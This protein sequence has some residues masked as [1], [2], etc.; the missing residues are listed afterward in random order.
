M[1]QL[2]HNQIQQQNHIKHHKTEKVHI[3]QHIPRHIRLLQ[4]L[5][6]SLKNSGLKKGKSRSTKIREF[7][8]FTEN[9]HADDRVH[10]EDGEVE[11]AEGEEFAGEEG[12]DGVHGAGGLQPF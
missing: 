7:V 5:A 8:V 11:K 2:G 6:I 10:E 9:Y 12:D 1:H 4:H 3:H